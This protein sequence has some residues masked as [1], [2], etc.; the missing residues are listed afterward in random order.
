VKGI[1]DTTR[2]PDPE[3]CSADW[4]KFSPLCPPTLTLWGGG[5]D[6]DDPSG[7]AGGRSRDPPSSEWEEYEPDEE[8][9]DDEA[10]LSSRFQ[11]RRDS[12][13]SRQSGVGRGKSFPPLNSD[14]RLVVE[15]ELSVLDRSPDD[16]TSK[17]V[18]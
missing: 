11:E 14:Q 3:W 12:L 2:M 15:A 8:E 1:W 4:E 13:E 9:G 10:S 7:V 18:E 17:A 6:G 16:I 5:G